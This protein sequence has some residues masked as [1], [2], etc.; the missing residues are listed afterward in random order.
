MH[1]SDELL[2]CDTKCNSIVLTSSTD[3]FQCRWTSNIHPLWTCQRLTTSLR[4]PSNHTCSSVRTLRLTLALFSR[5]SLWSSHDIVILVLFWQ[6]SI[7]GD[8]YCQSIRSSY[9]YL[10]SAVFQDTHVVRPRDNHCGITLAVEQTSVV[11]R[12]SWHVG[13][14][15][16]YVL[17]WCDWWPG[18]GGSGG[19]MSG[20]A[21]TSY[22]LISDHWS[23][24]GLVMWLWL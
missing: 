18:H 15:L 24:D 13:D 17:L 7:L 6:C 14:V 10:C 2:I 12:H 20:V 21:V 19:V 16:Q 22:N 9:Y 1:L 5:T 11:L 4:R 23:T 3:V 8:P